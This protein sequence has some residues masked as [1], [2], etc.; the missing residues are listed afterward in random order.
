MIF[1]D[2]YKI[3]GFD[4]NKVSL[5]DIK[6]AYREMAKKYHPD[7]NIGN[8]ASEEIFKDVNEAYRLLSN[9]KQRRKYDFTWNRYVGNKKKKSQTYEKKSFIERLLEILFGENFRSNKVVKT[10]EPEYGEDVDTEIEIS[11]KEAFFG[12]NKKVKLR[13]VN[14]KETSFSIKVPAG[15]QNNDKI[16]IVGQGKLGKNG[17]KNGDLFVII[18]IKDDK[19]LKLIG[20]DLYTEL[21]I[22]PS[23]AALGVKKEIELFE[24]KIAI[25]IP[26]CTSSNSNLTIK[27]KGY[28]DGHGNRGNLHVIT[29]IVMPE[30]L[31]QEQEKLYIKLQNLEGNNIKTMSAYQVKEVKNA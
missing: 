8:N 31:T 11:I 18:N 1:K 10:T 7:M 22:T 12:V 2:Y 21:K 17:G 3:L 26:K 9:D 24:E 30:K 27:G 4:T 13:T 5:D 16:R 19:K 29:R 6:N 25:I 28:K 23:E 15:I 14:G 20:N